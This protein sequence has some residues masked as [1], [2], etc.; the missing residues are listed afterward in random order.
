MKKSIMISLIVAG[1]LVLSGAGLFAG[2]M[3]ASGWD[4][5]V[6]NTYEVVNNTYD[7]DEP[8]TN[9]SI[10]TDK[11][12]IRF[13]KSSDGKC[14]VA[15]RDTS[16]HIYSVA[17]V[18]GTLHIQM[19]FK[20]LFEIGIGVYDS[21]VTIYLP[22]DAYG[23]LTIKEDT[24]DIEI[25]GNF[26]FESMDI[27]LD[28]GEVVSHADAIGTCRIAATTGDIKVENASVGALA[29]RTTS[30]DI[31]VSDVVCAG[32]FSAN[33]RTGDTILTNLTC[34]DLTCTD[35]TSTGTTGELKL[36]NVIASG[37]LDITRNTGDVTF[38]GS[39]AASIKVH[40]STGDVKGTLL[41]DKTFRYKTSTGRVELPP[42]T[43]GGVC[44]ITTDTGDIIIWIK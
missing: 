2:A 34:T 9:I 6:L 12:D 5:S 32:S 7:V 39:D 3:T 37:K 42:T 27:E 21:F 23:T 13:A 1:A 14:R 25:P 24:G 18:D 28:T 36:T 30:G 11:V 44:D 22:E 15:T 10:D 41:S 17:V 40:T 35:L 38:D 26:S 16:N 8:F 43:A 29:L 33:V 4:F 20:G 19:G 31:A